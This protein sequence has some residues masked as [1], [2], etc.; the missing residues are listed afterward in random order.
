MDAPL[1]TE[2]HRPTLDELPQEDVREHLWRAVDEPINLLLQGPKGAGK[3]AAARAMAAEVHDNPDN[4]L[5]VVNVEDFFGRTKT[6]IRQ[7]PRFAPFLTGKSRMAKRDMINHVLKEV[8]SYAPASGNFKTIV[9]D[10]AEAAR[11]DFQQALRRVMEQYHRNTQFVITTR[12]PSKLIA[13]IRS[14]CFPIAVRSVT[15]A[16]TVTVLSQIVEREGVAHDEDGL[17]FVAGA[18]GGDL[19]KAILSAQATAETAG[20]ITMT[21]AYETLGDVGYDDEIE[22]L[23]D[24]AEAGAFGDA[25]STLDELLVDEGLSASEVLQDL[26]R[27]ARS[28]YSDRELAELH[29]MA[30]EVDLDVSEGAN[31]RIHLSKLLA[32]L[33]RGA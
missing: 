17:E 7:D 20:E 22:G 33:G 14:R 25:R 1:W 10:N 5:V 29:H 13:P 27:V 2:A 12:Q 3:T 26:L 8:A 9:L 30:G 31:D 32:E 15:P 19:R 18:A 24:D 11:G 28:R 16:E 4:D 21:T 23:L 6:E